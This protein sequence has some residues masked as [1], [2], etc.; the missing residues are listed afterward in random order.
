MTPM[1]N[2]AKFAAASFILGREIRN[3]TNTQT[4]KKTVKDIIIHTLPIGTCG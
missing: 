2:H 1:N 3:R 4:E